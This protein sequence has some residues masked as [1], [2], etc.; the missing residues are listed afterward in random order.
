MHTL[1]GVYFEA[2][3]SRYVYVATSS[4]FEFILI[5][6]FMFEIKTHLAFDS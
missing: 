2:L 3:S 6:L 4:E 1:I 5:L